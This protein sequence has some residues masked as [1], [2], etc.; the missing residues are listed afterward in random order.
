MKVVPDVAKNDIPYSS[1]VFASITRNEPVLKMNNAKLITN[2]QL[3]GLNDGL[4][5]LD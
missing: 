2:F 4:L 1:M 5:S 3:F